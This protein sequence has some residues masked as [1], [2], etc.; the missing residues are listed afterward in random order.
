MNIQ[1][2]QTFLD[3]LNELIK[4]HGENAPLTLGQMR[5]SI[6]ENILCKSIMQLSDSFFVTKEE[7]EMAQK[8][9]SVKAYERWLSEHFPIT[10]PLE[11]IPKMLTE[12]FPKIY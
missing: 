11:E 12:M 10:S 7:C 5:D 4:I 8:K 2:L 9:L 3:E 1:K 6:E